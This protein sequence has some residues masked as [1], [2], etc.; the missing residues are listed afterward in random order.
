[1]T[2]TGRVLGI[3]LGE[4]R[5]GIALSDPT[6]TLAQPQP[7][8]RRRA[9][10]RWPIHAMVEFA[11]ANEVRAVVVGLPLALSGEE[12]EWCATVREVGDEVGRRASLPVHYID[13]RMTSVRAERAVRSSGLP[14]HKREQKWRIDAAAAVFILQAWLDREPRS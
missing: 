6:W 13:E 10:K 4:R 7:T 14:K 3:D 1:M 9:G 11:A 8:M 5:I 2:E 12:N